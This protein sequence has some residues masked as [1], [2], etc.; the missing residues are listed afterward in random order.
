MK[1]RSVNTGF[2]LI[3][4]LIVIAITTILGATIGPMG[5]SLLNRNTLR[6]KT[7]EVI[8]ALQ[9]ARINS[10]AGKENS[11]WGV[12]FGSGFITLFKGNSY[13]SRDTSFDERFAYPNS[14]SITNTEVVFTK[15]TGLP[16]AANTIVLD[17]SG[18]LQRTILVKTSGVVDVQ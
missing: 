11:N 6:T 1:I 9:G 13:A 14:F 4:L 16:N 15:V 17:G 5:S 8:I 10:I 2:S 3:E 18:S 12:H 7:D